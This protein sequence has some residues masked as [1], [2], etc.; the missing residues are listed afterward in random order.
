MTGRQMRFG[1]RTYGFLVDLYPKPFREHFARSMKQTFRDLLDDRDMPTSRIWLSVLRDVRSSLLREHLAHLTG[2][3]FMARFPLPARALRVAMAVLLIG[4]T[5]L[6]T[7]AV[8]YYLG[9]SEVRL[10]NERTSARLIES[11]S[12]DGAP[13]LSMRSGL[14][15]NEFR[16]RV[17]VALAVTGANAPP[18]ALCPNAP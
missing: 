1:E 17:F 7:G 13:I 12:R 3:G 2:S 18:P 16:C 4:G 15:A 6:A 11:F 8:G 10:P 9:H 5:S 14:T